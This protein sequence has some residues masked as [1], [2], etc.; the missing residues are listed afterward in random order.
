MK[1]KVEKFSHT[2]EGMTTI[3]REYEVE[4]QREALQSFYDEI[5]ES[6]DDW[7][8]IVC[9]AIS[10]E[11]VPASR[12]MNW[13]EDPMNEVSDGFLTNMARAWTNHKDKLVHSP[14]YCIQGQY[15][16]PCPDCQDLM[17][18]LTG[19]FGK[20]WKCRGCGKTM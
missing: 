19:K 7:T 14:E 17:I 6:P 12:P 2:D 1:I 3:E 8:N 16:V 15:E 13:E 5:C 20:F 4:D 11:P 9:E 10:D 18:K